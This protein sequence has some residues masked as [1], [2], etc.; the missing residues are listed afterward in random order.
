MWGN[1]VEKP[2]GIWLPWNNQLVF[3]ILKAEKWNLDKVP[4]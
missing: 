3:L 4:T 2:Y 1:Q